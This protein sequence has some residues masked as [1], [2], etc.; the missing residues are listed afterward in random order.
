M[1]PAL[2]PQNISEEPKQLESGTTDFWNRSGLKHSAGHFRTCTGADLKR[3]HVETPT[4][5]CCI[6][7]EMVSDLILYFGLGV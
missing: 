7:D 6:C 2:Q 3:L 4:A 5:F 1:I